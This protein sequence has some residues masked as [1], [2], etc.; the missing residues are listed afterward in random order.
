MNKYYINEF[1]ARPDGK[2]CT[3]QIQKA[4]DKCFLSGGGEVIVPEGVFLT[5]V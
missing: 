5:A 4:I 3:A 1:G 2:I